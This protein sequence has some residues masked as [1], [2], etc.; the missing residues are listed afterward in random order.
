[1]LIDDGSSDG[2][3]AAIERATAGRGKL[4]AILDPG[5]QY[6]PEDLIRRSREKLASNVDIVQGSAI[7][8]RFA[9]TR[10]AAAGA[11]GEE[12]AIGAW[13][14]APGSFERSQVCDV[15][16]KTDWTRSC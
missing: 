4:V 14:P 13:T 10:E 9:T 5:L 16:R 11:L 8:P 7:S 1:M 2:T 3:R 6:Q 12:S 15:H